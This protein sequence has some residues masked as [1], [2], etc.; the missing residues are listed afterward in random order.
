[1]VFGAWSDRLGRRKV[2]VIW[3]GLIAGFAA[4]LLGVAQSW[5]A[6]LAAAVVM[7]CSYGVYTSVDFAMRSEAI[8][9]VGMVICLT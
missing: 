8:A 2:F 5:P 7:G 4:F 3:S 9:P 6:A 1:M